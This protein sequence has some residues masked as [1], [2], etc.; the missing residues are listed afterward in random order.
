[1]WSVFFLLITSTSWG[2]SFG[3][4][5]TFPVGNAPG[6]LAIADISKDGKPDL[7]TG[8]QGSASVLL[9][10]GTGSFSAPDNVAAG[11]SSSSIA[12]GDLNGDGIL[13]LITFFSK[14]IQVQLGTGTGSFGSP[15]TFVSVGT[16]IQI[17]VGDVNGDGKLDMITTN[18]GGGGGTGF[19]SV[20]LGTGTGSFAPATTTLFTSYRFSIE[21][22]DVNGDGKLDIIKA[23]MIINNI[24][25]LLGTGTGGF[26]ASTNFRVGSSPQSMAVRDINSDGKPDIITANADSNN[27][28]V[29]LGDG[30]GSLGTPTSFIAGTQPS[31]VAVGDMNGDG[32]LDIITTN[33]GSANVSVLLGDGT[34][35][36]GVATNLPVGTLPSSVGVADINGDGKSDIIT[37]NQTDNTVSVLLNQQGVAYSNCFSQTTFPV[38]N[39]PTS[40]AVADV[41][42]DG[43]PDV[44]TAN[45]GSN[46]V[47]VSLG[48]GSFGAAT[49]FPTGNAP[50][51]VAV[52]DVDGD[53]HLDI[54]TANQGSSNISVL[55]GTGTGSF[56]AAT[57]FP[58]G[59]APQSMTVADVN[60]DGKL[61][62]I[63]ANDHFFSVSVLLGTGTGSFG[64]PALYPT[65]SRANVIAGS[66]SVPVADVNGDGNLDIIVAN[67]FSNTLFVLLG[68][69]TGSFGVATAFPLGAGS[70]AV[71]VADVNGDGKPD[72]I[73]SRSVLLGTGTG[74]FGSATPLD[75]GDL[76]ILPWSLVVTDVN[77]DGKADLVFSANNGDGVTAYV[78]ILLGTGTGSFGAATNFSV[79]NG[80]TSVAV[81]DVDSDGKLD[82]ITANQG[83]NNVS[84]LLQGEAIGFTAQPV[85]ASTVAVGATVTAS[86]SVSG[87][88]P[89]SYQ[90]YRNSLDSP[91]PGQTGATLSLSNVQLADAGSYS[92]VVTDCNSVTSTAFKLVVTQP[93][94]YVKANGSGDGSS[95][96]NASGNLQAMINAEGVQ[97]V[98]VAAGTYKPTSTTARDISFSMKSGVSILGGFPASGNPGLAQRVPDSYTTTLS[99]DIGTQGVNTDNSYNVVYNASNQGLSNTAILDGFV[100]TGG[101][102]N[103]QTSGKNRGGGIFLVIGSPIVMNCQIMGN[104]AIQGGGLFAGNQT[105]NARFIN[106]SFLNNT[107]TQQGGAINATSANAT[108]NF[109]NCTFSNNHSNTLQ[110]SC[111]Y[112][113]TGGAQAILT[114]CIVWNNDGQNAFAGLSPQADY[115][116]IEPA[117]TD[118]NGANNLTADPQFINV[119][120][121]NYR[122]QASSPAINTGSTDSYTDVAGPPTDLASNARIRGTSIDIGA[123]ELAGSTDLAPTLYASPATLYGTSSLQVVVKVVEINGAHSNGLVTVH[124]PKSPQL[125]LSLD[126]NLTTAL[127]QP[128]Q[129][130]LWTLDAT[131]STDSYIL[132]TPQVVGSRNVLSVGLNG[133][134]APGQ[135]RGTVSV[136]A[137]LVG[138]SGGEVIMTNNSDAD[139]LEYFSK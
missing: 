82:I 84:V 116:L 8:N 95:W 33:S 99:G 14:N 13:D 40:V 128:V 87:T 52:E 4:Q 65:G 100:I 24:S 118:Y 64:A 20:F 106:C 102:A 80:P 121:G 115:C 67:Y 17:K 114:N 35:S 101:N 73:T 38:G 43:K 36:F 137:T 28:S 88:A 53:G 108:P 19:I 26:V 48:T 29:F 86:V 3:P 68:T 10:T 139:K 81:A 39:G 46:N 6:S 59:A 74:S 75:P 124:I 90:W 5:I 120:G 12:V 96:A 130:S 111:V 97:Q 11:S 98:W 71:A 42:Q 126:P 93:I 91:L 138:S 2:Q 70:L 34:G 131:S 37:T 23:N 25:V 135:T 58:L 110:G 16:I 47:S 112:A 117:E 49:T 60:K 94:R 103:D 77:R 136:T 63:T 57:S 45:R 15:T 1:M 122:L 30:T 129:N 78:S 50:I 109:L 61:D 123:Y 104:S 9:G 127:G 21:V 92:V 32:R 56:G 83:S 31:S 66:R 54:M 27:V 85:S 113:G 44:I 125:S 55:L 76:S 72:V 134:L 79:G 7:I 41:N 22:G 89:F 119:A 69:G 133:V 132:T 18:I 107:A 62:V 105:N 51:S